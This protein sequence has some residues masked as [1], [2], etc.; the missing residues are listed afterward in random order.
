MLRSAAGMLGLIGLIAALGVG[1]F[2]ATGVLSEAVTSPNVGGSKVEISPEAVKAEPTTSFIDRSVRAGKLSWTVEEARRINVLPGFALPPDPLHGD[3]V[4]VTFSVENTSEG[5][6]TLGSESLTL[7]DEMGR[8]SPPA[9]SVNSEYVV[10]ERAILFNERGLLEPGE[11]KEGRV[12][13]DLTV[14]FEIEPS[15][16]LSGFRLRLDDA[17]PTRTDEKYVNLGF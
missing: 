11:K 8:E 16:D 4:T 1:A 12:N 13:F 9:A 14:P 5:P 15:A 10:P 3:F 7:V 17:E 6:V 2:A